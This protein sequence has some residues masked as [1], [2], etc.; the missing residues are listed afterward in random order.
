M[1]LL[2]CKNGAMLIHDGHT[3]TYWVVT[4]ICGNPY[5]LFAGGTYEKGCNTFNYYAKGEQS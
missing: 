2:K 3:N 1:N 5:R 4:E